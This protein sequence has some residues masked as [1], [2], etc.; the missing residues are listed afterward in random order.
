MV[1]VVED[2][3]VEEEEVGRAAEMIERAEV[4]VSKNPS[5][6]RSNIEPFSSSDATKRKSRKAELEKTNFAWP[7]HLSIDY[8]LEFSLYFVCLRSPKSSFQRAA[9]STM[10]VAVLR[11]RHPTTAASAGVVVEM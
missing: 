4:Q 6:D 10:D 2:V 5:S 1:V 9:A 11:L 7:K 8:H 3:V